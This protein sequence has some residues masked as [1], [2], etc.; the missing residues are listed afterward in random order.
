MVEFNARIV[1]RKIGNQ[2]FKRAKSEKYFEKISSMIHH[3]NDRVSHV[4]L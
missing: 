1:S 4:F 2:K 3:T